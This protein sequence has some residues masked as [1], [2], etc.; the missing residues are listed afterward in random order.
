MGLCG[1]VGCTNS[2]PAQARSRD[3]AAKAVKTEAVRQDV[4]SRA[5][6]VVGTLAAVDEVIVS[7]EAEGR[8][9][10]LSAD[11][12]D[13]VQ[14]GQV[15]V[16]LDRE[17]LQYNADLRR[18]ALAS[19]LA[20]YGAS[21]PQKLPPIE[22]T[23]DVQKVQAELEQAKQAFDRAEELN[24]RNLVPKQTL[25]DADAALRS[26]EASRNS[27]LQNAKNL[28]ADIDAASASVR[29]AERQLRDTII[30]AP[31]EGY[32]QKRWVSLGEFVKSQTPVM[33]VVRV[34]PLKVTAEIP[35]KQVP[36][37]KVGQS[38]VLQ[39][40]AYPG[41]NITGKISRISPAVSTATRAFPFEALVPNGDALLKP[42]TF[43]RVRIETAEV[44]HV[45]T[46]PAAALQYRYGVYRA[47]LVQGDRLVARELKVGD[48]A[49]DRV[50]IIGSVKAGDRVATSDIERLADGLKVTTGPSI[51]AAH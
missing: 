33:S 29:L 3:E 16:E 44:D 17:K 42:G 2:K 6:E 22:Q 48:R 41:K 24:K 1:S 27:A 43:A 11:L 28:Q 30:R 13:R 46:L 50:E 23:P 39:V 32:V 45:L 47:F 19:A 7:A 8:V 14:A 35:E 5:A 38:V 10:R 49:G 36:W 4:I 15:L 25:D 40:D 31:F 37:I 12:G 26:K 20:R 9:S 21:D 51:D 18:A 34:D